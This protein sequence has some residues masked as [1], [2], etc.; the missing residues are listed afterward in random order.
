MSA[1]TVGSATITTIVESDIPGI[2]PEL[3][4]PT[5]SAAEVAAQDWLVP[6]Y[7]AADGTITLRVQ[8]LVVTIAGRRIGAAADGPSVPA[9]E[10]AH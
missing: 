6:D 10:G 1:W 8:A 5:G 7:A 9:V 2:P 3:F 4:F